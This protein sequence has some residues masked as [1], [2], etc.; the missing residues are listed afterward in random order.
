[1]FLG[2]KLTYVNIGSVITWHRTGDKT[3]LDI[4][5]SCARPNTIYSVLEV[6]LRLNCMIALASFMR[7]PRPRDLLHGFCPPVCNHW[8]YCGTLA[9]TENSSWVCH[10]WQRIFVGTTRQPINL[11]RFSE[12]IVVPTIQNIK[13]K[14]WSSIWV[15][16]MPTFIFGAPFTTIYIHD[17]WDEITYAFPF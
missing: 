2:I 14:T 15:E 5:M 7:R 8:C 10:T 4:M 1:M 6:C 13:E 9:T 17:I 11:L 3:W 12:I 16:T